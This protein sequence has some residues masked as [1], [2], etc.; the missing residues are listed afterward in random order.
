MDRAPL[1]LDGSFGRVL[2]DLR[3][4]RLLSQDDLAARSGLSVRSIRYLEA[5]RIR[6]PRPSSVAA[7]AL[8]LELT[9]AEHDEF[10]QL[11]AVSDGSTAPF[12]PAQLPRDAAIFV[13]RHV[14]LAALSAA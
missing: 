4:Q 13:G 14:E 6:R 10:V 12:A 8:A 3:V 1:A 11:S 2:R 9:G 5:D 7:L